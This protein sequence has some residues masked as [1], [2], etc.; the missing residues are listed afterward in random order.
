MANKNI[1][2][3]YVKQLKNGDIEG[4]EHIYSFYKD[5][6]Y[7]FVLSLL[8]NETDAADVT[9][10]VFI[11]VLTKIDTLKKVGGFHSWLFTLAYNHT[12]QLFRKKGKNIEFEDEF[13]ED[14][15]LSDSEPNVIANQNELIDAV[16]FSIQRLP[17][18]YIQIAQLYYFNEMTLSEVSRVLNI[19][20]STVKDRIKFIERTLQESLEE[21][22]FSPAKY[23]SVGILPLIFPAMELL[24]SMNK[25]SPKQALAI[26][27]QI[28]DDKTTMSTYSKKAKSMNSFI[29]SFIYSKLFFVIV[30]AIIISA[31][32]LFAIND[33]SKNDMTDNSEV[34]MNEKSNQKFDYIQSLS[35][36]KTPTR[37]NVV[38][39]VE[40]EEEVQ[41]KHIAITSDEKKVA[42][43]LDKNKVTFE[44]EE[45]GLYEVAI[46]ND[47]R[48]FHV[49][50]I[51]KELPLVTKVEYRDKKKYVQVYFDD[52]HARFD[53]TKSYAEYQGEK[54]SISKDGK[55]HGEFTTSMS[56]HVFDKKR[57]E[58]LL[59]NM[60][61]LP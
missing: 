44:V 2:V 14:I 21:K 6:I 31:V 26:K 11:K 22:G 27:Q 38:V 28:L 35:Y 37:D 32:V 5:S 29:G 45:N 9:Q 48:Q 8:K 15:V 25:F 13:I 51:D 56:L 40:L 50:N 23:F 1:D 55:I 42:F 12:M 58:E 47:T 61:F 24:Q 17:N 10:E 19:P 20:K 3:K 46:L 43:T 7:F 57:G 36:D 16:S 4:F 53:L 33:K 59:Y 41:S 34:F 18:K 39:S 52:E 60:K 30:G 49:N 54:Y